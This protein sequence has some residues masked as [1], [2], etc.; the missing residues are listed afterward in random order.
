MHDLLRHTTTAPAR[1]WLH[2]A[3]R[4]ERPACR[5]FCFHHAGGSSAVFNSWQELV[6]PGIEVCPVLLPGHAVRFSE[7]LISDVHQLVSAALIGLA[8]HMDV[9]FAFFGHSM[10]AILAHEL[11]LRL[12]AAGRKL[13]MLLAVSARPAPDLTVAAR[14]RT[15]SRLPDEQLLE[16]LGEANAETSQLMADASLRQLLLPIVRADF[17]ICE[18]WQPRL[19]DP[20]DVPIAAFAG[21]RDPWVPVTSVE[22][23]QLHTRR[24]FTWTSLPGDHFIYLQCAPQ[25]C[26]VLDRCLQDR[27]RLNHVPAADAEPDMTFS[28]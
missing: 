10:G 7:P 25:I 12:R 16:L 2:R 20:L 19:L 11:T 3:Q 5:L 8:P 17:R 15:A 4:P 24:E 13:P 21:E 23:W 9:P 28:T 22:R 18:T 1:R 26:A 14:F 6:S 27:R